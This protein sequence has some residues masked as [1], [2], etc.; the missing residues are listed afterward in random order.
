MFRK[1]TRISFCYFAKDQLNFL[2]DFAVAP[3]AVAWI[4]ISLE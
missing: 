2:V 4:E 1:K 3:H